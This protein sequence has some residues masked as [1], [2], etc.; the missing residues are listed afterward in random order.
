MLPGWREL[1]EVEETAQKLR[2]SIGKFRDAHPPGHGC[3]VCLHLA[4]AEQTYGKH[5]GP[6]DMLVALQNAAYQFEQLYS[7]VSLLTREVS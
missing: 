2:V 6:W 4:E 1:I 7:E 3:P 5:M